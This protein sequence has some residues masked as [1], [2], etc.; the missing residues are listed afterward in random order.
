[1][2]D[3]RDARIAELEARLAQEVALRERLVELAAQLNSTPN[4]DDLLSVIIGSAR[5]LLRTE[6]A[7]LLLL[8]E[9]TGELVFKVS[10]DVAEVRMPSDQGIA[11]W[12]VQQRRPAI[13]N[14]PSSDERFYGAIGEQAGTET[15][16]L[17]AAPL[18][19][20]GGCVG[21]VEV[22]NTLGRDGFDA[23][24]VEVAEAIAA[25][26]AVAVE[27][28]TLYARLTDAVVEARLAPTAAADT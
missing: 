4:L 10:E 28:A 13:V 3:E 9:E 7:S 16:N 19:V 25:L 18:L 5:E 8:D 14:D 6:L 2:T 22:V 12:A 27:N 21:V 15:R 23:R 26:A 17:I 1:M 11:G 20:K 24:D